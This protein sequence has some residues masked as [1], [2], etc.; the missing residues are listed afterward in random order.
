[1]G[2]RAAADEAQQPHRRAHY[3]DGLD[4]QREHADR[5][6]AFQCDEEAQRLVA[7]I[8]LPPLELPDPGVEHARS[9]ALVVQPVPFPCDL[10]EVLGGSEE[11]DD[12]FRT[13]EAGV[14]ERRLVSYDVGGERVRR[15][16]RQH[17]DSFAQHSWRELPDVS[18]ERQ[19]DRAMPAGHFFTGGL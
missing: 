13:R 9:G 5:L 11:L 16:P 12:D 6:A 10:G 3:L 8:G 15:G 14:A 7:A 1:V 19:A 2:V 17:G 18:P 4:V